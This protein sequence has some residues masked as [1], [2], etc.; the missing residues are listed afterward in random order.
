[1]YSVE[2]IPE[3][4]SAAAAKLT[5]HGITNATLEIGD[6]AR[7]WSK[8]APYDVVL[9]T[10]SLPVSVPQFQQSLRPGGRML[11]VIGQPPVMQARLITCVAPGAWNSLT[12][13]ESCIP[14]LKNARQP[15]KFFF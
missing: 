14:P 1:V 12:L 5:A 6:G 3:F 8:H 15:E 13:F 2:I 11:A 4:S 7:G 9:V 10:G